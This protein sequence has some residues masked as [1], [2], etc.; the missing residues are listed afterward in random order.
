MAAPLDDAT[1]AAI[2]A[3]IRAGHG[4]A[5]CRSIAR[6]H[7]VSPGTVRNIAKAA[8]L[9]G[10]FARAKT[11]NATRARVADMAA[12]RAALAETLL[13]KAEHIAGRLDTP[14]I[15]V[16]TTKD[17]V[18]RETLDEPPLRDVKDGMAAVG[19]AV[20]AHVELIRF[21]TKEAANPA[22]TSLVDRLADM[23]QLDQGN[24]EVVDD[25][26]PQPLPPPPADAGAV[27]GGGD[28]D[29]YVAPDMG[30]LS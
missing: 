27:E 12:R 29:G 6:D 13:A 16:V 21:D 30:A 10:A 24:D 19:V 18:F 2:E 9:D 3:A 23:L 25:G 5:S 11:A 14:Y 17:D 22:A 15:V 1:R 28:D 7:N 20:K 4:T 8:G 26:Y